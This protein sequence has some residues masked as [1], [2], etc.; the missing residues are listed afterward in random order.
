MKILLS[1]AFKR[2]E[3]KSANASGTFLLSQSM[4]GGKTHNLLALGLL[5]RHPGL[6]APVMAGFYQPGPLGAVRVLAFSGRK[7][8]TPFGIWG[9]LAEQ[10]GRRE[11]LKDFYSPLT[12]P[13]LPDWVALLQGEPCLILLDELPPYFEASKAVPV[14]STTLD[15]ITT[16]ALAN[17]LEAVGG[18]SL[19]NVCV[20]LT[21]LSGAAYGGGGASV[22]AA[23]ADLEKETNRGAAR[24]DPVKLAS[25]E[26][27]EILRKRLFA[28][29][30]PAEDV[31]A[32]AEAYAR[33]LERAKA[34]DITTASPPQLKAEI[35]ASYPFHP[36][37]RDL[38]ARFK[39]NKNF[40]Q[41]RALIRIMR[42]IA[43]R[44]WES[45]A[46]KEKY[47]IG[48]HDFDLL[49]Q[50]VLSEVRQINP[51]LE[52]AVAHDI[53]AENGVAV[54]QQIDGDGPPDAQDAA[55]L[56]FLASL[57]QAVN[58]LL[59]LDRSEIVRALV[60]PGR[61]LAALYSRIDELR[62]G[63]YLHE[64]REKKLLYRDIQNL[65]AK[66]DTYVQG[67]LREQRESELRARLREMFAP[68]M[69]DVYQGEVA[70]LPALD[71]VQLSQDR[72][73]LVVYRPVQGAKREIEE[74]FE[75]QEFKN[76][77][78]FLT[79]NP[80]TYETVL[81]RA[82]ELAAVRQIIDELKATRSATA[83]QQLV[84]AE[85]I[86]S[87]TEGQFYQVCRETF[88][89]LLYPWQ[90]GLNAVPLGGSFVANTF[91]GEKQIRETL[92]DNYKFREDT[93]PDTNF[94]AT[95]ENKLW[96]AEAK[97]VPWADIRRR[98]ATDPSWVWHHPRALETLRDE[99]VKRDIWRQSGAW[100]QRGPFPK[101]ETS[102]TVLL[103]NRNDETGEVILK[104]RPLHGD[105][106]HVSE[107]GPPTTA[108]ERLDKPEY[109]TRAP[110]VW[111]LVSDS[112][113]EHE[114]GEAYAWPNTITVK[115]R[116]FQ[117]G[118]EWRCELRAVPCGTLRYTTDGSGP[119]AHGV[120]Y[121]EPFLVPKNCRLI[122]AIADAD[123][124]KSS[125]TSIQPPAGGDGTRTPVT[126][127]ANKPA[128]W[129]RV[130]KRDDTNAAYTW[131]QA[132]VKTG[133]KVG[134][135]RIQ[136]VGTGREDYVE[137][138]AGMAVVR[139][140]A[141]VMA[142]AD[143]L[144]EL[145]PEGNLNLSAEEL[146][147]DAGRDLLDMVRELKDELKAGEVRQ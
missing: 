34:M 80:Q 45:G 119:E 6:R 135:V 143:R 132:A 35:V 25:N 26:L 7:T 101:P 112:A 106:I 74:F 134:G 102:I 114:T 115:H 46:A 54:A 4:G 42:V 142:E 43:A 147:F 11:A 139:P 124:V 125:V 88:Q 123:G 59:G 37:I 97:E 69:G 41:T 28:E 121:A 32:V 58:P 77:A 23:L 18:G 67:K 104:L 93:G 107:S 127:D 87:R 116:F 95:L 113:G 16:T 138:I 62:R 75:H 126:V 48:A 63:W 5:A 64:T 111:F 49:Q 2:L 17:L 141:D 78:L 47:L 81:Q 14:G 73:T 39:E 118:D 110:R 57:S 82:A 98:A 100:V 140:A 8:R 128:V 109:T 50:E 72:L 66:L 76:R 19:P 22:N 137:L 71:E 13:G 70:A 68:E 83:D 56:I 9:E 33:E 60:A 145:I 40:Q 131:L 30:P 84:E 52:P 38:Y 3:G 53:A 133:A 10:L 144:K 146:H 89:T 92:I 120:E 103:Q 12:A 61:D 27:Y 21:D 65:N 31:E 85:E 99:L 79:G 90:K 94:R 44:L 96:P 129:A 15:T 24:L 20:V 91:K 122:L 36:A 86:R 105:V 130:Q 136:V 108:S 29:T 55:R 117:D 51:S 1:E